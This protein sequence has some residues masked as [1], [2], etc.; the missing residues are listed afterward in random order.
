MDPRVNDNIQLT[1]TI[2]PVTDETPEPPRG[3]VLIAHGLT[4][5]AYQRL[6]SDGLYHSTIKTVLSWDR[7]RNMGKVYIVLMGKE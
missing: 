2:I 6:Y 1:N 7:L 3:T 5:T 4:G